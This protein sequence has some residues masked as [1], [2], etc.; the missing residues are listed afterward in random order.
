MQFPEP[1][2]PEEEAAM[3]AELAEFWAQQA[4]YDAA[5]ARRRRACARSAR[6]LHPRRRARG[7][8]PLALGRDRARRGDP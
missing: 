8:G 4:H 6:R 3:H 2:T 5:R 1:R 7:R